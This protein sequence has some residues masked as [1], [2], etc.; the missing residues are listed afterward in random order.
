MADSRTV[1][2]VDAG[3]SKTD[4]VLLTAD[5]TVLGRRRGGGFQPHLGRAAALAALAELIGSTP[6]GAGAG[7]VDL[8]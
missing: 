6:A 7:R 1:L 3:N 4:A 5:G 8:V 2:A